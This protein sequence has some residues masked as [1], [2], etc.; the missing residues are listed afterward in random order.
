MHI[1]E[2]GAG[3]GYNAALLATL[4]ATV[5]SIDVQADVA[6]GA[7]S[8]VARAGIAGVR[9]EHADGYAG[10]PGEHFDRV[11]VT[12][13]IG[14]ISPSWLDQLDP[15]GFV[16]APVKHAGT[17]PVLAVAGPPLSQPSGLP[18]GSASGSGPPPGPVTATVVCSAGFMLASGPLNAD[19]PESF[20][21]PVTV[22]SLTGL[23]PF[24]PARFDP[25]LDELTYRNLWYA[26]GAW[27]RRATHTV[28][29]DS[30]QSRV[31]LLDEPGTGG[32]V[33]LPDGAVLASDPDS[34]S[35]ATRILDQWTEAGRPSLSAWRVGLTLTGD[36]VSPIW[37]PTSWR[38]R[39][40]R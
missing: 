22:G 6:A 37:A 20:P 39:H 10:L 7:R 5:T 14:G 28:L 25:P 34:G 17:H 29:P 40:D 31:A 4:G 38:L 1:L 33:I 21:P 35:A 32:A 9:V 26:A 12:V 36:P 18:P 27:D 11:I 24:A 13:G 15:G 8:A 16:I 30:D 23:R 2:I 19:H 3:T